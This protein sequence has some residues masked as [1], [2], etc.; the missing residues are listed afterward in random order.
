MVVHFTN[1]LRE[2]LDLGEVTMT[3]VAAGVH[4][5]WYANLFRADRLQYILTTNAASLYSV[6]MFGRGITDSDLYIRHF[7]VALREQLEGANMQMIYKRCIAPYTGT[8]TLAKTED[9][10]VLGSMNDM[11]KHSKHRLERGEVSPWELGEW[12]NNTPFGALGYRYPR[13]VF[14]QLPPEKGTE[15]R[16]D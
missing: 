13:D 16:A 14:A 3:P 11:V 2:K 4:L 1:K 8:I 15:R 5:R 9:R 10:S 6:V 12:I 7:L